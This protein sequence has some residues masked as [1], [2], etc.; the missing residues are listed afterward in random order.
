M[1]EIKPRGVNPPHLNGV[2]TSQFSAIYFTRLF[3]FFFCYLHVFPSFFKKNGNS[4]RQFG[5]ALHCIRNHHTLYILYVCI[6]YDGLFCHQ[7]ILACFHLKHLNR[8]P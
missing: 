6:P 8:L 5:L 1:Q 7:D 3:F 2:I 4:N